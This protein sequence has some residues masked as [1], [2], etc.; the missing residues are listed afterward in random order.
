MLVQLN[1]MT[2]ARMAALNIGQ[3]LELAPCILGVAL[4]CGRWS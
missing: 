1:I 3:V 2:K 4:H